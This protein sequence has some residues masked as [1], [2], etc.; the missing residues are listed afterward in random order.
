[1]WK[2]SRCLALGSIFLLVSCEI[3]AKLLCISD[4]FS[5]KRGKYDELFEISLRSHSS[6]VN[7]VP[8]SSGTCAIVR[9]SSR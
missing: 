2:F 8:R 9:R 3:Y 5:I 6:N 1:M 4:N 7:G